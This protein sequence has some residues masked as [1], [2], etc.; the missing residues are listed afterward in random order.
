MP[1]ATLHE[2]APN[3]LNATVTRNNILQNAPG[4]NIDQIKGTTDNK[5][6]NA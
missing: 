3:K 5:D 1:V 2:I 4:E 6:M